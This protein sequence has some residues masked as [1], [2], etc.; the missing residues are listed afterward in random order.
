MQPQ[1]NVE[2]FCGDVMKMNLHDDEDGEDQS[3][4]AAGSGFLQ[5]STLVN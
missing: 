4:S 3:K 1:V 5:N 2:E